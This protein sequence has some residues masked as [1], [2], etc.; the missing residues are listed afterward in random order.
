[1]WHDGLTI[2]GVLK[3]LLASLLAFIC[4]L[5][6]AMAIGR[7]VPKVYGSGASIHHDPGR[8]YTKEG[9]QK[10]EKEVKARGEELLLARRKHAT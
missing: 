6:I 9:L 7:Y 4:S 2:G 5:A 8:I 3:L 1:M 10:A